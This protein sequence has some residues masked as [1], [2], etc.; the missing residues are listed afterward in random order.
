MNFI[1]GG[2][3]SSKTIQ[4]SQRYPSNIKWLGDASRCLGKTTFSRE[5]ITRSLTTHCAVDQNQQTGHSCRAYI[6]MGNKTGITR[7]RNQGKKKTP[8]AHELSGQQQLKKEWIQFD[9]LKWVAKSAVQDAENILRHRDLV[10]VV[11]S[12]RLGFD[13]IQQP[14]WQSAD[15]SH[16]RKTWKKLGRK[17]GRQA[18]EASGWYGGRGTSSER[19]TCLFLAEPD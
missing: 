6:A 19:A 2:G 15:A 13:N 7:R 17:V 18:E 12:G 9:A 3:E 11:T 16:R 4:Q 10:G 5:V 1:K 14:L 8:P